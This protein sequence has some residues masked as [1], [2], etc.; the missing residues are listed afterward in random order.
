MRVRASL[1]NYYSPRSLRHFQGVL[2]INDGTA[3]S[4]TSRRR[5]VCEGWLHTDMP[6]H[7]FPPF[8]CTTIT[9]TVFPFSSLLYLYSGAMATLR[10]RTKFNIACYFFYY[11]LSRFIQSRMRNA[12]WEFSNK[13]IQIN[14]SW[15]WLH[16][17][18][19][20]SI[21]KKYL[22]KINK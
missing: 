5:D 13:N 14:D 7:C 16:C 3:G 21:I 4:H 10:S 19:S 1:F 15:S 9:I 12:L 2:T 6:Q 20:I 18:L 22:Y 11:T 17:Y 8:P